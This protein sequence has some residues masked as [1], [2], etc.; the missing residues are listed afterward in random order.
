MNAIHLLNSI[1]HGG[2]ENVALNYSRVL[3]KLNIT[4]IIIGNTNDSNYKYFLEQF[5]EVRNS[6]NRTLICRDA[7]IFIHSNKWLIKLLKYLPY[8]KY[9][10]IRVI[11]VQHLYYSKKKFSLLSL[12]INSICTDFIRITPITKDLV[13]KYIYVKKHFIANFYI[14]RYK[15]T[16][17]DDIRDSI[18]RNLNIPSCATIVCFSAILKPGKRVKDFIEL[19]INSIHNENIYFLL[20]GDGVER[21]Y[22]MNYNGKNL[23]WV[24]RVSDVEQYLI[25]SDVYFFPS[26]IEMM[27]MA[28]LEAINTNK[29]II[30]YP[31]EINNFLLNGETYNNITDP[32]ILLKKL[33]CG[34]NLKHYDFSY[35]FEQFKI[36][37]L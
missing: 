26:K 37:G 29:Q 14:Q 12:L 22:I 13:E 8:I 27:P 9:Y 24:G 28:L 36:L 25:A 7:I 3:Y 31:T 15:Q 21:D 1:K 6:L 4:S 2:A 23:R 17:W 30:A 16:E 34:C 18:R 10:K 33:P 5:A 35:G 11:Y 19:A 32:S 20:V